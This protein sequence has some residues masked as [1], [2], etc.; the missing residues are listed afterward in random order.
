MFALRQMRIKDIPE[1]INI[2][3]NNLHDET[4]KLLI[5][6]DLYE[7]KYKYHYVCVYVNKI[8][9][10]I[11]CTE[12]N[13]KYLY[14]STICVDKS[15]RSKN[16]GTQLINCILC[17]YE[18]VLKKRLQFFMVVKLNVRSDNKRAIDFYKKLNFIIDEKYNIYKKN[19]N[20]FLMVY[21]KILVL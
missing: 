13:F 15:F 9:G 16:I 14:I 5:L 11:I 8:I 2:W 20:I 19:I 18:E 6:N 21:K 1:I 4:V 7:N 10:F 3:N 12:Q 17:E